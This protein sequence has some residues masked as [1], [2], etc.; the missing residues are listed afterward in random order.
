MEEKGSASVIVD[1]DDSNLVF[2]PMETLRE[3]VNMNQD[4]V[5]SQLS[6]EEFTIRFRYNVVNAFSGE[7]TGSGLQKLVAHPL[8]EAIY[9]ADE[10]LKI[11][12]DESIPLINA[13]DVWRIPGSGGYTR[14]NGQVVCVIDTGIDYTHPDFGGCTTQQFLSGQCTKVIGG[15][16]FYNNDNDPIDDNSHGTHVAGI[17]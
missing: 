7:V 17:V 2:F 9:D 3:I 8:V 12:L 14:G 6:E 16:D 4:A 13:D 15:W 1:L 11:T 5:L 10:A